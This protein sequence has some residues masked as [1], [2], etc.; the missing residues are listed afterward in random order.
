VRIVLIGFRV[1][2]MG[3]RGEAGEERESTRNNWS[4]E[5]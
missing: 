3:G 4:G 2:G 5:V 1:Q